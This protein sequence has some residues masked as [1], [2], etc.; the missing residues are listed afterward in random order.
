MVV[1]L[2]L[3]NEHVWARHSPIVCYHYEQEESYSRLSFRLSTRYD[4]V[5]KS[6]DDAQ[7]E[8]NGR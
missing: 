5:L 2:P 1:Q 7:E 8:N 3:Y 4:A 6:R